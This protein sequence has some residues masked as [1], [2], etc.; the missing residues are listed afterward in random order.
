MAAKRIFRNRK[1]LFDDY[2]FLCAHFL[3]KKVKKYLSKF[4]LLPRDPKTKSNY[5]LTELNN[6][7]KLT[8]LI[9]FNGN[10]NLDNLIEIVNN[11]KQK[12]S[13]I[14]SSPVKLGREELLKIELEKIKLENDKHMISLLS[15][16]KQ[17]EIVLHIMKIRYN[18]MV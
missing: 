1:I 10:F 12:L 7:R 6:S 18:S 2:T 11:K 15:K 3:E 17:E 8:E 14:A 5:L 4:D 13:K 9:V 16:E